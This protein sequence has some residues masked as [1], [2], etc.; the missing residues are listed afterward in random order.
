MT[1]SRFKVSKSSNNQFFFNLIA[2]NGEVVLTSELYTTRDSAN[3]GIA[4][5]RTNAPLDS[6]Y[7]RRT[8]RDGSAYFVLKGGNGEP[9]GKSE[10]Y[11]SKQA[12]EGG[13][14]AVKV[15]G[16]EARVE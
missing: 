4:S 2:R 15:N 12:M 10:M 1:Q 6:R 16:P 13:I 11:S 7:D 9:I 3:I 8:A 5:V 14:E